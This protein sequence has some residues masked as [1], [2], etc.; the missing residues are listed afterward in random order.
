[1]WA[2][3]GSS[4]VPVHRQNGRAAAAAA[5]SEGGGRAGAAS[6]PAAVYSYLIGLEL[7]SAL[8]VPLR[9]LDP[10]PPSS[11]PLGWAVLDG[12]HGS[13]RPN[14][15]EWLPAG[16]ADTVLKVL[17]APAPTEPSLRNT[18]LRSSFTV[19]APVLAGAKNGIFF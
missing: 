15:V 12:W 2:A 5:A 1:V 13:L 19:V 18:T 8:A 6:A 11:S 10:S 17:P 3:A 14:D 4:V 16:G 9:D 7:Q